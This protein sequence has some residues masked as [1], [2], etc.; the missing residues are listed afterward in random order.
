MPPRSRPLPS[1]D[2]RRHIGFLISDVAR[3]MRAAFDRRVRR[4]GLTRSQWLV[5]SRLHRHPGIS[6][7]ELAEMLEVERATAG[8][9]VDR[10]ERSNWLVR[11]PDPA[12]RRINRLYLTAEAE[13]VQAEMGTIAEGL[14]DEAMALL[15]AGERA[16]LTAM[17]ERVKTQL[18]AMAQPGA[19]P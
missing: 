10:L 17:M 13:A 14:I 3:L 18:Q 12:D 19:A 9:M 11:Q 4:L 2:D 16:A 15:D 8:R 1:S 7:S 6:Q 5:L